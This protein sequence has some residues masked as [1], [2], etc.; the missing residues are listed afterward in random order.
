MSVNLLSVANL[1]RNNTEYRS[2]T[3]AYY[4]IDRSINQ[5]IYIG[6]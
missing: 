4:F 2:I 1:N 6:T 3:G 5:V